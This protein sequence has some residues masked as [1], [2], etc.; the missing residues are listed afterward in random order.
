MT[1]THV[2]PTARALAEAERIVADTRAAFAAAKALR[3]QARHNMYAEIRRMIQE[4][5]QMSNIAIAALFGLGS[6]T[7]VRR[8]RNAMDNT[9]QGEA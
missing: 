5:P 2:H 1:D 9:E 4:S 7:S 3:D 8:A 6:E